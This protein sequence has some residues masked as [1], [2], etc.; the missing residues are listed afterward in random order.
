MIRVLIVD[1][2]AVVRRGLEQLLGTAGDIEVLESASDG[3]EAV[4]RAVKVRPDV[5]LM[6]LSMPELDGIEATR[7]VVAAVEGVHVVV[8][9]S[10][11]DQR[12]VFDAIEAG[13]SGYVLKD[14]SPDELLAAVRA[15]H[16]GDAPFDPKAARILL[17]AQRGRQ[18]TKK[19]SAREAE[20]LGLLAAGMANK[21]IARRLGIA[22]RTV[23]AHLTA[24]FQELG[25][26]DRTQAALWAREHLPSATRTD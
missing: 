20:V 12:R 7:Q 19:L 22:E 13:A 9:T 14:A 4:E 11:A 24:V 23:K 6:D 26:T 10:F 15:A 18:P 21:E 25:V 1:D 17:E 5:V 8:L 2:H 3:I 16:A